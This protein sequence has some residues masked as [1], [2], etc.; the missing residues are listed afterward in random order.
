MTVCPGASTLVRSAVCTTCRAG[1][2]PATTVVVAGP[3]VTSCPPA[4]AATVALSATEPASRS[5]CVTVYVAVQ[6][7]PTPG[8]SVATRQLT[9]GAGPAGAVGVSVTTSPSAVTLPVLTT[10]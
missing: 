9:A 4:V 6:V 1:A 7:V 2:W 8:A 5:A 10:S 3:P